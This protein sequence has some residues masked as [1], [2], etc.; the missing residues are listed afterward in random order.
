[1]PSL[2]DAFG[3]ADA[4]PTGVKLAPGLDRALIPDSAEAQ[5]V[6]VNGETVEVGVWFGPLARE[7]VRRAALVVRDRDGARESHELT[8]DADSADAPVGELGEWL[9]EPDGSVIRAR[10]IGDLARALDAHMVSEGIAWL[11]SDRAVE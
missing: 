6:S 3:F 9:Y 11:T 10:L 2:D 1:S 4:K 7:G 8:A 5:W